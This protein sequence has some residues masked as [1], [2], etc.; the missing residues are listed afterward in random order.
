MFN[1]KRVVLKKLK[2]MLRLA[3]ISILAYIHMPLQEHIKI[4]DRLM[5]WANLP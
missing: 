5:R 2:N 4:P 3:Y 1:K